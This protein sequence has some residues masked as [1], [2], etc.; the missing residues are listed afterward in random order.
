MGTLTM[1]KSTSKRVLVVDDLPVVRHGLIQLLELCD[2][3][4][5]VGEAANGVEAIAVAAATCPDIILMDLEM[6]VLDGYL[7]SAQIK[8]RYPACRIIALSIHLA[9]E[10]EE[11]AYR[12]G[13]DEYLEKSSSVQAILMAVM[14]ERSI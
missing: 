10:A 4:E 13:V 8:R 14:S 9:S 2:G 5:V 11:K 7:A 1:E 6:P 12:A 3:V